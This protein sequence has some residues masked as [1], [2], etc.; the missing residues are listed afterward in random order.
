M[1]ETYKLDSSTGFVEHPKFYFFN[2]AN[3]KIRKKKTT[4]VVLIIIEIHV[5]SLVALI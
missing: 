1:M 4:E 5:V 2:K 3:Y